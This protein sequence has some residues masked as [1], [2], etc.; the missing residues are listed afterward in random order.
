MMLRFFAHVSPH[1]GGMPGIAENGRHVLN[2][3]G[4]LTYVPP[5]I[6]QEAVRRWRWGVLSILIAVLGVLG[7]L[8]WLGL[9]SRRRDVTSTENGR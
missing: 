7:L 8:L 9:R 5:E 3:H 1:G 2:N 4:S 6:H